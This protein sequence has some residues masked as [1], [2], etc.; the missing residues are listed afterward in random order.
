MISI[1]IDA[2]NIRHGGGRTHLI[3]L[4]KAANPVRDGF[5]EIFVWGSVET[6]RLIPECYWIKKGWA[7][8]LEGN[9]IRR[10]LW[11]KFSLGKVVRR[12]N[13]DVMF[14]PGGS[15]SNGFFPIVS[16]SQNILPFE[17]RELRRYGLSLLTLRLLLLRV[18]Q[19]FSFRRAEGVIFLTN[20]AHQG[21]LKVT[22]PLSGESRVIPHGLSPRFLV[23]D[24]NVA[25]RK[26]PE[27]G[28]CIRLIYVSMIDQYKH[29][30][31]VVEGVAKARKASGLDLQ[32][33]LIGPSYAPALKRLHTAMAEQDPNHEWV[34]YQGAVDHQ[35]LHSLYQRA[36]IGIWASSCETFGLILLEMMGSGLPILSSDR[37]PMR[38]ILGD[39]GLYFDPEDPQGLSFALLE[40]LASEEKMTALARAAH[41][42]AKAFS[43]ERCA[44]ESFR[45]LRQIA[46]MH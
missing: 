15:F 9:L 19:S 41:Q 24:A 14:V 23:P 13:C 38:E 6:L 35:Q 11:Q 4:L 12:L 22:G 40:L 17:W 21:V 32:L 2:T 7:P 43:W 8:A 44:A 46:E 33:D 37:G 34:H 3:E 18:A 29:Q 25:L 10:T 20:Y 28:G 39:T 1:F 45:F 5:A 36:N 27:K 42:K 16:M 31:H 30:W 26:F